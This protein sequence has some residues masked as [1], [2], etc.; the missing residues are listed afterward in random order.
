MSAEYFSTHH[1]DIHKHR[2]IIDQVTCTRQYR[3]AA[4]NLLFPLINLVEKIFVSVNFVFLPCAICNHDH[5]SFDR[6]MSDKIPQSDIYN[7]VIDL[8]Y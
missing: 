7:F 6:L 3:T 8:L 4:S 2:R 1:H 5:A